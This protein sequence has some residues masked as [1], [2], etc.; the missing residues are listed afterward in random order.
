[1]DR[2]RA[3]KTGRDK[4]EEVVRREGRREVERYARGG[5]ETVKEDAP[6]E[7]V[8]H[9]EPKGS[10]EVLEIQGR[11]DER[12]HDAPELLFGREVLVLVLVLILES[13]NQSSPKGER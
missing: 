6:V 10:V 8:A 9:P 2:D 11:S 12:R 4:R 7:R 3:G 5:Q 1:M 13:D